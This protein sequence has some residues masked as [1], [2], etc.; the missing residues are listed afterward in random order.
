[1]NETPFKGIRTAIY[2]PCKQSNVFI[3]KRNTGQ[4][5]KNV[6]KDQRPTN[7]NKT[8]SLTLK[9][10]SNSMYSRFKQVQERRRTED[11]DDLVQCQHNRLPTLNFQNQPNKISSWGFCA[12]L[13]H[14]YS[15]YPRGIQSAPISSPR[16][17]ILVNRKMTLKITVITSVLFFYLRHQSFSLKSLPHHKEKL[18]FLSQLQFLTA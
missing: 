8:P 13:L 14:P 5:V 3:H 2:R 10:Q 15:S 18:I 9:H 7:I 1:M 11:R 6:R 4:T 16:L 12:F 17:S